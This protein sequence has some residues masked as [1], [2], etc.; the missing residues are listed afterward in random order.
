VVLVLPGAAPVLLAAI[1]VGPFAVLAGRARRL[2][3]PVVPVRPAAGQ[4]RPGP[5]SV[6]YPALSVWY[7]ALSVWY[8]ALSVWYPALS[9][10]YPALSVWYPALSVRRPALSV[11]R[12]LD[13]ALAGHLAI[14]ISHAAFPL[15]SVVL[16]L[17][18]R[19]V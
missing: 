1:P 16:T 15:W 10:W 9:V 6:R 13:S 3:R 5:A 14:L 11:R 19:T 17:V 4:S 7:P 8:P 18:H 12:V 2:R